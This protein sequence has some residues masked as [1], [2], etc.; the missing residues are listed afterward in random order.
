MDTPFTL[1]NTFRGGDT[2]TGVTGVMEDTFGL[3]RVH[4]TTDATLHVGQPATDGG[5]GGR[6]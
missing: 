5:A 6:W 2:L 3:Y 1:T 4:P